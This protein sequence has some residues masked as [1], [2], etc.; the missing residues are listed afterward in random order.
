MGGDKSSP[1]PGEPDGGEPPAPISQT[2]GVEVVLRAGGRSGCGRGCAVTR[3]TDRP[4]LDVHRGVVGEAVM[5]Y[6]LAP[7]PP[8]TTVPIIV[9]IQGLGGPPDLRS[10]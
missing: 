9:V 4:H 10:E 3:G 1:P 5:V 6:V 2:D 8:V 7:A